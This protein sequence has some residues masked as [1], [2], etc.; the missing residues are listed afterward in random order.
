MWIISMEGYQA[1][2]FITI[3]NQAYVDYLSS[4]PGSENYNGHL[5][6]VA[7]HTYDLRV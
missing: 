4:K 1:F 7:S 2:I 5:T 6:L 3:Y